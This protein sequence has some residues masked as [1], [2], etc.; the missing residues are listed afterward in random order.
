MSAWSAQRRIF[1]FVTFLVLI[2]LV[3]SGLLFLIFYNPPTCN[4]R[5]QNGSET[6][7]DCGGSCPNAC[8]VQWKQL[9]PIVTRVFPLGERDD[10]EKVYSAIAHIENQNEGFYVPSVQFEITLHDAKGGIIARASEKTAIM[11]VDV[12]PVF[13]PFLRTGKIEAVSASFRFTEDPQFVRS[14]ESYSFK[15]SDE[16]IEASAGVSPRIHAVVTNIGSTEISGVD[17]VVTVYDENSNAVGA[18]RTF[19]K[20]MQPGE[21]R[22]VQYTWIHPFELQKMQ[23]ADGLCDAQVKYIDIIPVI[24]KW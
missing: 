15:V 13:V 18:S 1:A 8:P 7:V 10:G 4:D 9:L 23:C 19:E 5:V 22:S 2:T 21:S 17:F 6:G 3:V 20:Y 14:P 11:P 16:R 12:T 24:T